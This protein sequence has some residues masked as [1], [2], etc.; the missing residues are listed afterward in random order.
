MT[1]VYRTFAGEAADPEPYV[2]LAER[3]L[4]SGGPDGGPDLELAARLARSGQTLRDYLVG[5]NSHLLAGGGEPA[6]KVVYCDLHSQY[7]SAGEV[8]LLPSLPLASSAGVGCGACDGRRPVAVVAPL[9]SR[10]P[11]PKQQLTQQQHHPLG[12]SSSGT[13]VSTT[14]GAAAAASA[15][16]MAS[17]PARPPAFPRLGPL[18]G[19]DAPPRRREE[20]GR[21]GEGNNVVAGRGPRRGTSGRWPDDPRRLVPRPTGDDDDDDAARGGTD[22]AAAAGAAAVADTCDPLTCFLRVCWCC[23]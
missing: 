6:R 11:P 2:E 8:P 15:G 20:E 1:G 3:Q 22:D 13:R 18:L 19:P 23:L 21:G 17:P 10:G 7:A 5:C 12:A 16:A 9:P 4:S 14:T